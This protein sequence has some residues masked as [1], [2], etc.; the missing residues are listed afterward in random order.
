MFLAS[1]LFSCLTFSYELIICISLFISSLVIFISPIII[2]LLYLLIISFKGY[3]NNVPLLKLN[4]IDPSL[5]IPI[6][7]LFSKFNIGEPDEPLSV[8]HKWIISYLFIL[9][10]IPYDTHI[11]FS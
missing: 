3:F 9:F 2:F 6:T 4:L 5:C 7:L 10:N 1:N 8:E 11:S